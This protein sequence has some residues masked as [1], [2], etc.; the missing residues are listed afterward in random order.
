MTTPKITLRKLTATSA[1]A[2]IAL[3]LA[4]G[5]AGAYA[6]WSATGAG[7]GSAPNGTMKAVTVDALISGDGTQNALVPGGAADVGVRATNPNNFAVQVYAIR[8]NGA[9]AADANHPGCLTTGVTFTDPS[10]PLAP[11]TTIPPNSSVLITLPGAA[12]MSLASSS[13][14]QGASFSLPVTLEARK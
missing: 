10:A 5:A 11:A 7:T 6:Y 2:T 1:A 3:C 9:A 4:T 13:G 12:R 8:G 14:C